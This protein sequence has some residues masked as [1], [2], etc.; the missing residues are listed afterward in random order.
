[1]LDRR[2]QIGTERIRTQF[3]K[4]VPS[5]KAPTGAFGT[6][7][8]QK[9]LWEGTFSKLMPF[10]MTHLHLHFQFYK[11]VPSGKAPTLVFS[12]VMFLKE[13]L[14]SHAY[15][16]HKTLL[17]CVALPSS[18]C[19]ARFI[20][21]LSAVAVAICLNFRTCNCGLFPELIGSL[22]LG[23]VL[24]FVQLIHR[25]RRPKNQRYKNPNIA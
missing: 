5:R 6:A 20:K 23:N 2:G 19:S 13:P 21:G 16:C 24:V 18:P 22:K 4:N 1:M 25:P 14:L 8:S 7:H 15:V 10:P 11:N 12:H 3:Y 17:I 9:F